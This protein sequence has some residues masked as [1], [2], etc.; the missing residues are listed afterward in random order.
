MPWHC[1]TCEKSFAIESQHV[2]HLKTHVPCPSPDCEFTASKRVVG[3]HYQTIHGQFSGNGLKEIEVE[4]QKF[5]VLVGDSPEDIEKWRAERRKRWP[6]HATREKKAFAGSAPTARPPVPVGAKR[7]REDVVVDEEELEDGEIEEG[8]VEGGAVEQQP[9]EDVHHTVPPTAVEDRQGEKGA[10]DEAEEE[11]V[12]PAEEEPQTAT[13]HDGTTL[14]S[15]S[16]TT[17]THASNK[18]ARLQ[19]RLCRKFLRNQCAFGNNCHFSHD[20]K[21]FACR[22]MQQHGVCTKGDACLYSHAPAVLQ[23]LQQAKQS[24]VLEE[25]WKTESGSLLRKLLKNDIQLEQRKM[26][27]IVRFLVQENYFAETTMQ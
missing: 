20:R 3:V 18:Q 7:K 9:T 26:L 2:A 23:K 19:T 14:P 17:S 11:Y 10:E 27:Q 24:K 8:Q 22:A 4:G 25:K 1:E 6:S 16:S 12:E 5:M 21:A 15:S 13:G